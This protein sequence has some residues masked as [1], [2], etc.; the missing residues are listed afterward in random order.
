MLFKDQLR[1]QGDHKAHPYADG[2]NTYRVF[3]RNPALDGM[4][5]LNGNLDVTTFSGVVSMIELELLYHAF[6]EK[7]RLPF[8]TVEY[9]HRVKEAH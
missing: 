7:K 2:E 4:R 6:C 9:I 1:H 3:F 8:D 5:T